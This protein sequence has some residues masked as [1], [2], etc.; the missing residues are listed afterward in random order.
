MIFLL[1]DLVLFKVLKIKVTPYY[2][3]EENYGFIWTEV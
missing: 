1:N 3:V 2:C